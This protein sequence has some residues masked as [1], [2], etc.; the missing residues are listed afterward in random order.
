MAL[1]YYKMVT[2]KAAEFVD[3][4]S[5]LD[6]DKDLAAIK[7]FTLVDKDD[8]TAPNVDNITL[9]GARVFFDRVCATLNS[10]NMQCEASG[11]KLEDKDTT[12]V[13]NF[14]RDLSAAAD[15]RLVTED[16]PG[17][18]PVAIQHFAG[19]G[20]GIS[21]V[22]L[23]ME[24]DKLCADI[25]PYDRRYVIYEPGTDAYNWVAAQMPRSKADILRD[26]GIEVRA[27]SVVTDIWT[28]EEEM[29]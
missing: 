8:L 14:I 22:Y 9:N 10:S 15:E 1:D 28:D 29:V 3:L 2:D 25:R 7:D 20:A 12:L 18:L 24:G 4:H 13:E 21:R 11:E 16:I 6:T 27:P 23:R 19:R 26:Y 5:R 17:L